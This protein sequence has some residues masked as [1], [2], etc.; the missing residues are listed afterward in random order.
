MKIGLI[1]DTH[2]RLPSIRRAVEIFNDEDVEIILHGGDHIAPFSLESFKPSNTKLIGVCGNLDAEYELLR[3]G[4]EENGWTFHRH[5]AS[6]ELEGSIALL[7][8]ISDDI[9]KGLAKS[10]EFNVIV[11]GH[12]HK[13][14]KKIIEETLLVCPGEACGYL[15]G[16]SSIA[17]LEMPTRKLRFIDL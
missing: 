13:R 5:F 3:R 16:K 17:V 7:H 4:Y 10:G 14:Q 6:L 8:G 11:R 12:I 9:V 1:S 2:D 15:S